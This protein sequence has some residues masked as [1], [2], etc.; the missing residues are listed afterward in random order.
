MCIAHSDK[1]LHG[2]SGLFSYLHPCLSVTASNIVYDETG[3]STFSKFFRCCIAPIWSPHWQ[4]FEGQVCY[5]RSNYAVL[6]LATVMACM[7]YL[8][9]YLLTFGMEVDLVWKSKWNFM[10]GLYLFQRYLSFTDLIWLVLS[11][12][13]D[14]FS[15]F[16]FWVSL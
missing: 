10:K 4:S 8:W 14:F 11:C 12:Q 3:D 13:S 9:D 7:M 5:Q 16:L 6:T 2:V 15:V 1:A